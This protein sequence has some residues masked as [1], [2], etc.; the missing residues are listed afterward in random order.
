MRVKVTPRDGAGNPIPGA[1]SW[2]SELVSRKP[3]KIAMNGE[4]ITAHLLKGG[5]QVPASWCEVIPS[6]TPEPGDICESALNNDLFIVEDFMDGRCY[7]DKTRYWRQEDCRVLARKLKGFRDS[8]VA[9]ALVRFI[10]DFNNAETASSEEAAY[11]TFLRAILGGAEYG[12]VE[13]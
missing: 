6:I 13:G 10:D 3:I 2:E 5:V 1:G 9:D 8:G 7:F 12:R 4:V 11:D